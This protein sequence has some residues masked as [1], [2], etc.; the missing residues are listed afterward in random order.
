MLIAILI[1]VVLGFSIFLPG[2]K[3]KPAYI[4]DS[5]LDDWTENIEKRVSKTKYF[6]LEEKVTYVYQKDGFTDYPAELTITTYRSILMINEEELK[7]R[8]IDMIKNLKK[9][10]I[11]V[12]EDSLVKGKRKLKNGHESFFLTYNG[13]KNNSGKKVKIIGE[14]WNCGVSHESVICLG[15]TYLPENY[16]AD[17]VNKYFQNWVKIVADEKG[18]INKNYK[19]KDGLIY[20]VVCH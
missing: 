2:K 1:V 15:I 11:T 4:K 9:E 17:M 20:N 16:T 3:I 12:N 6:G 19:N 5:I 10:E 7:S 14:V 8:T 13:S 18:T